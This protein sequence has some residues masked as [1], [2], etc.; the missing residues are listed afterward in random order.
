MYSEDELRNQR[1]DRT[2][3]DQVMT[4]GSLGY[5]AIPKNASSSLLRAFSRDLGWQW[6]E[7]PGEVK[8]FG[9]IR[10][11]VERWISG[12]AQS[13]HRNHGKALKEAYKDIGPFVEDPWYD[14]H[15]APQVLFLE[16]WQSPTLFKFEHLNLLIDWLVEHEVTMPELL[17]K[18]TRAQNPEKLALHNY[19]NTALTDEHRRKLRCYYAADVVLYNGAI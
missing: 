6:S 12:F 2:F 17:R 11:P 13:F 8:F 16:K 19:L 10:D 3:R 1:N 7:S 18:N 5:I 15:Q 9:I 14:L 4:D